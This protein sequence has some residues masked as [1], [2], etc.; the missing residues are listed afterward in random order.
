M[1]FEQKFELCKENLL[2][3]DSMG[4][5]ISLLFILADRL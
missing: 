1:G 5:H 4:L 3:S 2:K